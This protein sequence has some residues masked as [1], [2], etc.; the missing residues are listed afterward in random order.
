MAMKF[1]FI[2]I[3]KNFQ[4]GTSKV[5]KHGGYSGDHKKSHPVKRGAIFK[6]VKS[7]T[8]QLWSLTSQP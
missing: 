2:K 7:L 1:G 8:S 4:D 5:N 3:N 6:F